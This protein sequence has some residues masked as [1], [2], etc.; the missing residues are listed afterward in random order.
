M[1]V[2]HVELVHG[3]GVQQVPGVLLVEEVAGIVEHVAPPAHARFVLD[4]ATG[5]LP[6]DT[7]LRGR[8]KDGGWQ[9][10]ADRL[11]AVE[12]AG[13]RRGDDANFSPL[14]RDLQAIAFL[15]QRGRQSGVQVQGDGTAG[16]HSGVARMPLDRQ[17]QSRSR[18]Q[19]PRQAFRPLL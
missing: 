14:R 17:R 4:V 7:R 15:A 9:E 6:L 19:F 10:L 16:S 12:Q 2:Q 5:D 1:H 13:G 8:G 18:A 11:A 3:H